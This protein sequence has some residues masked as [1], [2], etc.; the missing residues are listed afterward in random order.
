[1]RRSNREVTSIED[2]KEIINECK[3]MRLAVQ[4]AEGIYIVPLN[5]GYE[6]EDGVWTFYYHSANEGRKIDALTKNPTVAFELDR[7]GELMESEK[8]CAYSY[9]FASVMGNGTVS[10]LEGKEKARGLE[11]LMNHQTGKHFQFSEKETQN[12][13]FFAV[14]STS[15][16][17]KAHRPEQ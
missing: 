7:E 9:R 13:S 14:K 2:I 17:A 5:F 8:A 10:F 6:F 4:D 1:M 12:V 3:V 11:I 16:T 15:L